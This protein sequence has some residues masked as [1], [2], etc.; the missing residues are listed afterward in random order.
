MSFGE[1][2]KQGLKGG[3]GRYLKTKDIEEGASFQIVPW[4]YKGAVVNF[5]ALWEGWI[6]DPENK[7]KSKPIKFDAEAYESGD[8]DLDQNWAI[9]DNKYAKGPQRPKPCLAFLFKSLDT[10]SI[11]IASFTQQTIINGLI[12][13]ID[14]ESKFF[15]KNIA[16][17]VIT[18]GKEGETK[19]V[20]DVDDVDDDAQEK[21]DVCNAVLEDF[22]F[23]WSLYIDG[24]DDGDTEVCYQDVLD[25][26]GDKQSSK[27]PAA[28]KAAAKPESKK[29][30]SKAKTKDEEEDEELLKDSWDKVKSP[31][32]RYLGDFTAKELYDLVNLLEE[33]NATDTVLY[34]AAVVGL[35]VKKEEEGLDSEDIPF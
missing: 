18:I 28:K 31:R 16:D 23:E 3:A 20:V 13:Y 29:Q 17:K 10:G 22:R 30:E 14:P 35:A 7:K 2:F 32:G 15:K 9:S 6:V 24:E 33:K 4:L 34:K 21:I 5:V 26:A 25:M 8:V 1:K 11:Q 19:W 27:K 12:K